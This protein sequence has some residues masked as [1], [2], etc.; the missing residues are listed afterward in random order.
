M[1]IF[2]VPQLIEIHPTNACNSHCF[3][4]N[5]KQFHKNVDNIDF[6]ILQ[7]VLNTLIKGGLKRVRISGGGEPLCYLFL[8]R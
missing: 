4:C 2:N 3:F 7:D 5:Q 1:N 8:K 6:H